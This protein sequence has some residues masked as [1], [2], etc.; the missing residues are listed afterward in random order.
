MNDFLSLCNRLEVVF[1][2]RRAW[3]RSQSEC[4]C[5]MRSAPALLPCT[6]RVASRGISLGAA[7]G[8]GLSAYQAAA[9]ICLMN[10][11]FFFFN[12]PTLS[13]LSSYPYLIWFVFSLFSFEACLVKIDQVSGLLAPS[14]SSS[15]LQCETDLILSQMPSQ[16]WLSRWSCW[17]EIF[18]DL[19]QSHSSYRCYTK[20]SALH[21]KPCISPSFRLSLVALGRSARPISNS[22]GKDCSGHR[23]TLG[24]VPWKHPSVLAGPETKL[25]NS[26]RRRLVSSLY[27]VLPSLDSTIYHDAIWTR[28]K[29]NILTDTSPLSPVSA[30]P[31]S[32]ALTTHGP[33]VQL[34]VTSNHDLNF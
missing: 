27:P 15:S 26:S 19:Q 21:R 8:T 7:P 5:Q 18:P 23:S 13:R 11:F 9:F 22:G 31:F 30:V 12:L 1:S 2:K 24:P 14:H 34:P 10:F 20:V 33:C 4:M 16:L 6:G 32:Q 25:T 28:Q 17:L 29:R 3:A